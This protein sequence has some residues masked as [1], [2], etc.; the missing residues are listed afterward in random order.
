[1]VNNKIFISAGDLSGELHALSLIKEIKLI[2]P[3]CYISAVGGNN[4]KSVVDDFIVNI[5]D[6]SAFGFLP[7]KP[8]FYLKRVLNKLKVYLIET[9][10]NKVI[11]VDYYGFHIHV[12]RFAKKLDIP[13]YYYISPQVWASRSCR[14]KKLAKTVK[15]MLVIFPFEEKLYRDN[16]VDVVF[17]G[18]PLVDKVFEKKSFTISTPPNIGLFP[19]SRKSVIKR[20]MPIILKTAKILKE[21]INAN[22]IIFITDI[23]ISFNLPKYIKFEKSD[24]FEKRRLLNFAICPSGT[25]SLENALMGVPMVVMYKLSYFNYFFVKTIIKVKYISLVNILSGKSIIPE[26]IQFNAVPQKIASSVIEHLKIENYVP[27]IKELLTLRKNLGDIG[28]S[29]R[30]AETILND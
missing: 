26:F 10:P 3:L 14:I 20:H 7:I 29:K 27:K 28:V 16:D 2:N 4:L 18:N 24:N 22:F 5:V 6:L 30:V 23:N 21:K 25:V 8:F 12:A 9:R 17:A 15:K 19:G 11:L 13:V 1:M